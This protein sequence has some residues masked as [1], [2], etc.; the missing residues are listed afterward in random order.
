M[1]G[2][3]TFIV[4][5]FLLFFSLVVALYFKMR[6]RAFG[7]TDEGKMAV[8]ILALFSMV[9]HLDN[10]I[11]KGEIDVV[12]RYFYNHFRGHYRWALNVLSELNKRTIKDYRTYCLRILQSSGMK[13]AQRLELL[14]VLYEIGYTFNGIDERKVELLRNIAKYLR[15]QE[16]D[17]ASLEYRYECGHFKNRD[18]QES[19]IV[20]AHQFK[21]GVAYTILGLKSGSSLKEV[22]TAYRELAKRYHPDHIPTELNDEMKDM[23]IV[24]FRQI[25][26]AYQYLVDN[27]ND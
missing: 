16:W 19:A 1:I 8:N 20:S 14:D 13:Y 25:N 9:I 26:E 6:Q 2:A 17:L 21:L 7:K 5:A 22:K 4:I 24:L 11:D 15:I 3:N 18:Q 10:Q 23:S 12:R 27:L